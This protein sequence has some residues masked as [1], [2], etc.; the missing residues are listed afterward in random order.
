M[1][2]LWLLGAHGQNSLR[3]SILSDSQA[4]VDDLWRNVSSY[5][6]ILQVAPKFFEPLA[7][8]EIKCGQGSTT[9]KELGLD[10]T[11]DPVVIP[12]GLCV[13]MNYDVSDVLE[14][15]N[16][17]DIQGA[18]IFPNG[19]SLTLKT[20]FVLVQGNLEMLAT[21]RVSGE[22]DIKFLFTGT[23]QQSFIPA[24]NNKFV[25]SNDGA[26]T[27]TKC[28]IGS[29]PFVVAGGKVTIHGIHDNCVTWAN[30]HDVVSGGLPTPDTFD[31]LPRNYVRA[32]NPFCHSW[33]YMNEDFSSKDNPYGWTGGYGALFDVTADGTF[34]VSERMSNIDQG[35][36]WDMLWIRSC[37]IPNQKYLFS[38]RVKL[39]KAGTSVGDKTA[40]AVSDDN[41]L[42]L[43]SSVRT[44]TGQFG[45]V[46]ESWEKNQ[47]IRFGKWYDFHATFE[48][49]EE[50]LNPE[51]IYQ[52][53]QLRG[54][55]AGVD[56]EIDNVQFS[57]PDP[58]TLPDAS[59]V[60][61]GNMILNGN[62]EAHSIH[63][64]PMSF[65][66]G[67]LSVE[68]E[69]NGNRYFRHT[70]RTSNSDSPIYSFSA[71]GCLVANGRYKVS[72]SLRIDS[73]EPIQTVL[74]IRSQFTDNTVVQRI[75][76]DCPG[77]TRGSWT[78][79][80]VETTLQ[81][82]LLGDNLK[83]VRLQLE[84]IGA[85]NLDMDVDNLELEL[86]D[87]SV[88]S[89]I[90]PDSGIVDCWGKGAEIL[91]TSHTLS[92]EDSQVRT[93]TK[94]P[95]PHGDGFVKLDFDEAIV[96][97]TTN[98]DS[99][100]FAVEVALLSRN[101]LFEGDTDSQDDLMGAHFMIMQT[102]T[103]AQLVD[104]AEFR[105]FGQQGILGRY[106]SIHAYKSCF[107]YPKHLLTF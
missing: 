21:R 64:Y 69:A 102:P 62:A 99:R 33:S 72:V 67:F 25:C 68:E 3:G 92:Y 44:P 20:P 96:P 54:P 80:S 65:N 89:I 85:A 5:T 55:E 34:R 32:S 4:V 37:L 23:N 91:I 27:P 28:K 15:T 76:A 81:P 100:D 107:G 82:E 24:D 73:D 66:G 56:I 95:T 22:P 49:N 90:V 71:L 106:V 83:E 79:C 46:K 86:L 41:C 48:Y 1:L 31:S 45:R 77:V 84:T 35:P 63:P 97:P 101:I 61:G 2:A 18:L 39:T 38:T 26:S 78:A 53:M 11:A 14:L 29:K 52:I 59:D 36:T 57:L 93:L 51:N 104:G 70:G 8:D 75:V 10:P 47:D 43:F 50:E 87:G 17:L 103:V 6:R 60:C 9:W 7:C 88:T 40:C 16:G 13:T 94:N 105:N 58:K 19:Y 42:T 30:L 74:E 12:C 98:Q